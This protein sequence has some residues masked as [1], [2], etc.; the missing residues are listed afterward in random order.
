MAA[1]NSNESQKLLDDFL[2]TTTDHEETYTPR[3]IQEVPKSWS[4]F[5][6]QYFTDRTGYTPIPTKDPEELKQTSV[7]T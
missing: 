5:L 1:P 6:P 4:S 3:K 7:F 2:E